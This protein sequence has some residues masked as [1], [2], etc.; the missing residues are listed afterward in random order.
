MKTMLELLQK[1]KKQKWDMKIDLR[2]KSEIKK[3]IGNGIMYQMCINYSFNPDT[4]EFF[5][6]NFHI[7]TLHGLV[8]TDKEHKKSQ[9]CKIFF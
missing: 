8:W 9:M 4:G 6:G 1:K 7:L 3:F 2:S 5:F